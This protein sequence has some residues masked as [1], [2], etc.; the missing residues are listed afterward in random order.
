MYKYLIVMDRE[1]DK[2]NNN[3][4]IYILN[5]FLSTIKDI[6]DFKKK[7]FKVLK[8]QIVD[9]PVLDRGLTFKPDTNSSNQMLNVIRGRSNC[10]VF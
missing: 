2:I 5:Y 4:I 7:I 6:K 8:N 3:D 1:N 9:W 10:H